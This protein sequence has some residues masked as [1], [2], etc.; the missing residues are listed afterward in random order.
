MI[1][2]NTKEKSFFYIRALLVF[3][4]LMTCVSG[5]TLSNGIK[6]YIRPG[7]DIN[8]I[9]KVAVLPFENFT[10]D[11]FAA[12]KIKSLVVI[13]LL[14]RGIDVVEPGE[15][16]VLLREM[17]VRSLESITSENIEQIG[18]ILKVQ[19]VMTGSV[20]VFKVSRGV[21]VSYPEVSIS[22]I[23]YEAE[24]SDIIWST[25]HTTGGADFWTRHF[26]AEGNTLDETAKILI[27]DVLDTIY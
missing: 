6:H 4:F 1:D 16:M 15:V 19:A 27:S 21:E 9:N 17:K 26:G 5:C 8:N 25:W 24:N 3:F 23:M 13:D 18:K 12:D 2:T 11:R 22:L 10:A 7:L 14:S 20:G